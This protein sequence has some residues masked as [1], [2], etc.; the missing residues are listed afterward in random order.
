[1]RTLTALACTIAVTACS[2]TE[3]DIL[4][5]RPDG[6][7]PQRPRPAPL[8]SWQI[9]LTGTLD[10]SLDV[11]SYIIDVTTPAAAIRSLHDAGRIVLCYFS[12][13]TMEPF[14]R[15][16]A[17]F[18]ASALGAPLTNYPDER[19][20]DVR[21]RTVRAIMQDR[22]TAAAAAGCDGIHPSGL[23]GFQENTTFDFTRADQVDYDRWLTT[24]AHGV[25]LSIG[26]VDADAALSG[27]LVADFD[28]SVLWTCLDTDCAPAAPFTAARKAVFLIEYGDETRVPDVCPKAR[29]LGLAAIIKRDGNLDAFRVGCP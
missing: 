13:G 12:A 16:A 21:D 2:G 4:R 25:G 5:T 3:G 24:V 19:W 29:S 1:M 14:R 18:P 9:Q 17:R 22:I 8:S 26:L 20:V 7:V 15:D 28:W 6:A 27:E 10:A 23:A 11:R